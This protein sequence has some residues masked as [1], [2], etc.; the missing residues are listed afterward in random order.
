[1]SYFFESL[2]Q[3]QYKLSDNS[4]HLCGGRWNGRVIIFQTLFYGVASAPAIVNTLN[5]LAISAEGIRKSCYGEVYIDDLLAEYEPFNVLKTHCEKL[6]LQW[7]NSKSQEGELLTFCGVDIDCKLKT[8]TISVATFEKMKEHVRDHLL[9]REDG[10]R[11]MVFERFQELC[12]F[13]GRLAKTCSSGFVH[14]H[15]ILS[16]L[17]EAQESQF[18]VVE[19]TETDLIEIEFWI[20]ER[21]TMKMES[22]NLSAGSITLKNRMTLKS[23]GEEK[24]ARLSD[25]VENS[26]DASLGWWGV[27]IVKKGVT[28]A[29]C[30]KTPEH[31]K[32]EGIAVH[33]CNAACEGV[34]EMEDNSELNLAVDSTVLAACF[35]N[36]RSTNPAL[37]HIL[38]K[39]FNEMTR[40]NKKV[41]LYWIPTLRMNKEG[42]D[43]ISRQN[44]MEFADSVGLSQM[45]V[46]HIRQMYGEIKVDLYASIVDNP[47]GGLYCSALENREDEKN[48]RV[49]AAEFLLSNDLRGR[50][51]AFP[52][53]F[54]VNEALTIFANL[55]WKVLEG[56]LQ[57]LF[58]V[59]ERWVPAVRFTLSRKVDFSWEILYRA[60][61]NPGKLKYKSTHSF[62]LFCIGTLK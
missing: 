53:D 61:S 26:S 32:N 20:R 56:K 9:T 28:K 60:G 42:A 2:L 10:T 33:E 51:L 52:P 49:N 29:I 11:H 50:F 4:I 36:K 5:N 41:R 24:V 37:N 22:F 23:E 1:M 30:G 21:R 17:G 27:K 43:K 15:S 40:G 16:R 47:F 13:I 19:L 45:G 7:K 48:L 34:F 62:S 14:A 35:N 58:I 54:L 59:R 12:G 55:D 38:G 8:M 39:I 46:Q 44:Y 25:N 31:L 18:P 6:G 57:I 3:H